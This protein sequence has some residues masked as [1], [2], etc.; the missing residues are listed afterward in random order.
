MNE[1]DIF[2][3]KTAKRVPDHLLRI[4]TLNVQS[5]TMPVKKTSFQ[6]SKPKTDII[7]IKCLSANVINCYRY[8]CLG[9]KLILF[10]K[11]ERYRYRTLL[12]N[13]VP[14]PVLVITDI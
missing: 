12:S 6:I 3:V 1:P 7:M 9:Q 8:Q 5:F 13:Q 14:V 2:L 10:H 11:W 4:R